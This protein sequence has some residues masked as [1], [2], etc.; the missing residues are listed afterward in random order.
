MHEEME[1]IKKDLETAEVDKK[2]LK[3]KV[4]DTPSKLGGG[5]YSVSEMGWTRW[6]LLWGL[7]TLYK[8]TFGC[9]CAAY[10]ALFLLFLDYLW[11]FYYFYHCYYLSMMLFIYV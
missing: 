5:R 8:Y 4:A 9:V 7:V 6:G 11:A 2:K 10:H 1:K 3:E